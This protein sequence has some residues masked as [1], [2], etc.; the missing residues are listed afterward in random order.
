MMTIGPLS[1]WERVRVRAATPPILVVAFML[2]SAALVMADDADD[3]QAAIRAAVD[4]AAPS[5][6][7]IETIG[8]RDALAAGPTTGLIVDPDGWIISSAFNFINQPTEILVRLPDGSRKPAKRIA[9]DRLRM[10]VLLKIETDR[11]LP[12]C[13]VSPFDQLRVG[14]WT[15]AVG[16]A[17]EGQRPNLTVGILSATDRVWGKAVQTDAAVSPNNY[18]GPLLDIRG[19]VIGVLVPLSPE[20]DDAMAGVE[21]YDSGIG[22]AV[23]MQQ[24]HEVLPRMKNGEDLWPG[25]SGIGLKGPNLYTGEPIV[26]ECLTKSSAATAGIQPGDR[27]LE[28]DG[29]KIVRAADVKREIGCRYAGQKIRVSVQRGND[30]LEREIVLGRAGKG[31]RE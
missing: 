22:F 27:I 30:R 12:V 21:W 13:E 10:L 4:R 24:I 2:L 1:L 9:T 6:V 28:I 31:S 15:I 23:P 19:R 20:A 3:E 25:S 29:R 5:V 14:Q 26:A 7:R 16:R 8:G 17:F 18:G 11:P